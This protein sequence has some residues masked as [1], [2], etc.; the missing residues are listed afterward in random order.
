VLSSSTDCARARESV[1][2]QLDGELSDRE[3]DSLE[4]HLRFC[5]DC[6]AWA[7][8]VREVT[9]RL[10]GAELEVPAGTGGFAFPRR[11]RRLAVGSAMVLASAAA[12]VATMF[13]VHPGRGSSLTRGG[14]VVLRPTSA[15][16][17]AVPRL[18]RLEDGRLSTAPTNTTSFISFRPI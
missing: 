11:T 7:D 17:V 15:Q 3:L 16:R 12:V 6:A 18:L 10:R 13:V 8:Q 14:S 2:V 1:S 5:P 9:L 4:T